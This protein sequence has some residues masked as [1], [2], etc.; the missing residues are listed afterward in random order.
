MDAVCKWLI[1]LIWD[2]SIESDIAKHDFVMAHRGRD[3][4]RRCLL[5][6]EYESTSEIS[7]KQRQLQMFSAG[8][9]QTDPS[10]VRQRRAGI[11]VER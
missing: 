6:C 10:Y 1:T 4:L 9:E 5:A 11:H 3:H 7:Y 8:H 2:V